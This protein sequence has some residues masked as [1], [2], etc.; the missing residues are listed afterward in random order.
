MLHLELTAVTSGPIPHRMAVHNNNTPATV[1]CIALKLCGEP[2]CG[3]ADACPVQH[4]QPAA[5]ACTHSC[6]LQLV[7]A[8]LTVSSPARRLA[9]GGVW[10][11]HTMHSS[12]WEQHSACHS[13]VATDSMHVPSAPQLTLP[14]RGHEFCAWTCL[15]PCSTSRTNT[16]LLP[17]CSLSIHLKIAEPN[18]SLQNPFHVRSDAPYACSPLQSLFHF[19]YPTLW[20]SAMRS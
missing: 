18:D 5:A 17:H 2:V 15:Q 16:R 11:V 12:R 13:A 9:W 4:G 7:S 6:Q 8:L 20:H 10:D 1:C 3:A 14:V 19:P